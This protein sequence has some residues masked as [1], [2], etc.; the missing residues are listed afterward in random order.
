MVKRDIDVHPQIYESTG[1]ELVMGT[2]R[3]AAPKTLE[4]QAK[5]EFE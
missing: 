4:V 1:V 3:F 2:G 5:E